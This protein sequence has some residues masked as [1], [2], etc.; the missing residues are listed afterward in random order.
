MEAN[1]FFPPQRCRAGQHQRQEAVNETSQISEPTG[2][3][4]F[5]LTSIRYNDEFGLKK[6]KVAQFIFL[7]I[8]L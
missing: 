5:S 4:P 1:I 3:R 2:S 7:W 8:K 6:R